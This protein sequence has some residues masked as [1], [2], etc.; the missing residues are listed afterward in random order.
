MISKFL[1]NFS[2]F[3]VTMFFLTKL[4]ILGVLFSNAVNAG[5]VAKSP[6]LG[7]LPSIS[8]ILAL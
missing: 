6:I 5:F 1:F 8:V 4:L 3:C 7:I 2:N